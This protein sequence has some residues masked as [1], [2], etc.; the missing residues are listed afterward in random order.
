M[1][2]G[3]IDGASIPLLQ[4]HKPVEIGTLEKGT[5]GV[6]EV[7]FADVF[8]NMVAAANTQS[9]QASSAAQALAAGRSDDI[10]G[11]MIEM[12]KAGIEMRLVSN[13]KNKIVDA[14]YELWRMSV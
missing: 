4:P 11:T 2:I 6:G 7:P 10:H 3:P 5:K 12:S 13:V 8:M 1:A 9:Q 14:F